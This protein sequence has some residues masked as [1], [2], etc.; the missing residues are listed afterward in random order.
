M[1]DD[2]EFEEE[3]SFQKPF[4]PRAKKRFSDY[5]NDDDDYEQPAAAAAAKAAPIRRKSTTLLIEDDDE[6]PST[7]SLPSS[8]LSMKTSGPIPY[9]I[10][11]AAHLLL[12]DRRLSKQT[13]GELTVVYLQKPHEFVT[14]D[15]P[16]L[17][18]AS[19]DTGT[20]R[21]YC[22]EVINVSLHWLALALD[23]KF[24]LQVTPK[25]RTPDEPWAEAITVRPCRSAQVSERVQPVGTLAA[26]KRALSDR[27]PRNLDAQIER[28]MNKLGRV[29]SMT[30]CDPEW[31]AEHVDAFRAMCHGR[32]NALLQQEEEDEKGGIRSK[33]TKME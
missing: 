24:T 9:R 16:I 26:V 3:V 31:A 11:E 23:A 15:P 5:A 28:Y 10:Q 1:L 25:A 12:N 7:R 20:S 32:G 17:V 19:V 30:V 8:S 2:D 22:K 14:V 27:A 21:I 33:L 13:V 18:C 4:P 6:A 29:D